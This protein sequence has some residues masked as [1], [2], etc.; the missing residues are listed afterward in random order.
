[1]PSE[2]EKAV[3]RVRV[4]AAKDA[5]KR[6]AGLGGAHVPPARAALKTFLRELNG[7]NQ[8]NDALFQ[9]LIEAPFRE[10]PAR[11]HQRR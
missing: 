7:P 6:S 1:M 11:S 4:E 9:L 5:L 2:Q 10:I 8:P 3:R